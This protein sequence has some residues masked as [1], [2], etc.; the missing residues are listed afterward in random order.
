MRCDLCD[1]QA[2]VHDVAEV[3]GVRIERHLCEHCAIQAMGTEPTPI[4][5]ALKAAA[6]LAD[7]S[8]V[9][10]F[11][12]VDVPR[13]LAC[14]KCGLTFNE[15]KQDGKLGCAAC[16]EAFVSQL[17]GILMR[18][19]EGATHHAGKVP[20]RLAGS[21]DPSLA[22]FSGCRGS[23]IDVGSGAPGAERQSGQSSADE[24]RREDERLR[25]RAE[26]ATRLVALRKQLGEAV[27][28]EQYERAARLRD[29]VRDLERALRAMSLGAERPETQA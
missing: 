19:H 13:T 18:A 4:A 8:S 27:T 5:T 23:Q 24:R 6:D 14:T 10:D 1:N 2:T 20:R 11:P 7:Q 15:F 21:R 9:T 12:I 3:N 26:M 22:R 16:Y 29:E 17:G 25:Q 28:S